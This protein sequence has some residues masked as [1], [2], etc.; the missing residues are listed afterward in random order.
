[1]VMEPQCQIL[2]MLWPIAPMTKAMGIMEIWKMR[3]AEEVKHPSRWIDKKCDLIQKA[4]MDPPWNAVIKDFQ[5]IARRPKGASA[6]QRIL[7]I[8]KAA[9]AKQK[10][11]RHSAICLVKMLS[12]P[13]S[14]A[15]NARC[16]LNSHLGNIE[17]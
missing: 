14:T 8:V 3:Q 1:M 11:D 9:Q 4:K 13:W 2:L 6:K 12:I 17:L 5:A 16:I 15:L 7:D 10:L